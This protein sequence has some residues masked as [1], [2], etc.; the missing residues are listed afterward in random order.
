MRSFNLSNVKSFENSGEIEIKPITIFVGKNSSGKSSLLRFPVVIYQTLAFS[1]H[2]TTLKLNDSNY[3]DFGQF[4]DVVSSGKD[5]FSFEVFCDIYI[6]DNTDSRYGSK[7]GK[8]NQKEK[9][10][11]FVEIAKQNSIKISRFDFRIKNETIISYVLDNENFVIEFKKIWKDGNFFDKNIVL[12]DAKYDNMHFFPCYDEYNVFELLVSQYFRDEFNYID[13][14]DLYE[15]I[16]NKD[17]KLNK[18]ENEVRDVLKTLEYCSNMISHIHSE[19]MNDSHMFTYIGPFRVYPSRVYRDE[20][21]GYSY[22]EKNGE[23]LSSILLRDY[24]SDKKILSRL[25]HILNKI[26]GY[27]VSIK[28]KTDGYFSIVLD[29][30]FLKK[31]NLVDVGFGISQLLPILVQ[32]IEFDLDKSKGR[33]YCYIEQPELHLH[34]A[35]QSE[36]SNVFVESVC[37]NMNNN[38]IIETHSEHL[39]RKFQ[40][41]IADKDNSFC[42]E[43]LKIYCVEKDNNGNSIVKEM[44]VNDSGMFEDEWP[45]GFFDQGYLLTK[46]LWS[47]NS[48][49]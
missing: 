44:S 33:K 2:A 39:I 30:G 36:L 20:E 18:T 48:N 22:V 26:D 24:R 16:L 13:L 49:D 45:T 15:K 10:S 3:V 23:Q 37:N 25:S 21:V 38:Y 6:D 9:C 19:L 8:F 27:S 14:K 31:K 12:R 46:E 40:V 32:I 28:K 4:N 11:I 42:K 41:L 7:K 29:D 1:R 47:K 43:M 34:P 35:M 17:F 5:H